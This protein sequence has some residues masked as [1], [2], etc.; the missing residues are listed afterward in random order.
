MMHD[1]VYRWGITEPS[2]RQ[3]HGSHVYPVWRT[4]SRLEVL[5][6]FRIQRMVSN[7]YTKEKPE[8]PLKTLLYTTRALHGNCLEQSITAT[9]CPAIP[10]LLFRSVGVRLKVSIHNDQRYHIFEVGGGLG[11]QQ[12]HA[13]CNVLD[14]RTPEL[15]N[16]SA[17]SVGSPHG[18]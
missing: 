13:I 14:N 1:C 3:Q 16:T 17:Y 9:Q 2:K 11:S 4:S 18:H 7:K 10:V 8:L 15:A 5:L 6:L 12:C